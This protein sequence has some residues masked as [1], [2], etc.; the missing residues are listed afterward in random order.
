[1]PRA[2]DKAFPLLASRLPIAPLA[3]LP[4]PIRGLAIARCRL[5]VK[6]DDRSNDV[7]GG[8][9]V[10]KLEYLLGDALA[11]GC[12]TVATFGAAGSNHATATAIHAHALGLNCINLLSRQ[13]ST[14]WVA[15]NLRRQI[16]ADARLV[17][18]DGDRAQRE[19]QAQAVLDAETGPVAL[20][21]MGGSSPLGTV[22]YVNAGLEL[23]AQ[24]EAGDLPAPERIY[25]PLGTMGTAVG[26]ALGVA[27]G[28]LASKVIAVRVVHESVG[29]RELAPGL[30][31]GLCELLL[32]I[33]P[34]LPLPAFAKLPLTIRDDQFG[35]GYALAT[36][37]AKAAVEFADTN[38]ELAL[39]TTYSGK[40]LAALLADRDKG[41]LDDKSILFWNTYSSG[42]AAAPDNLSL[43]G[44]PEQLRALLKGPA[45]EG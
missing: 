7:Y 8:N 19:A 10:R 1:M 9:K 11:R 17:F 34:S 16:A 41:E 21:P 3:D 37:A 39:E 36:D 45:S 40:A 22:G 15:G 12:S 33:D 44:V 31:A 30:Y 23:A 27:L 2:L 4:T 26:L 6:C 25:L 32:G 43:D 38:W 42:A 24:V 5:A 14:P 35:G 13:R 20:I 18:V 28:G 29:S